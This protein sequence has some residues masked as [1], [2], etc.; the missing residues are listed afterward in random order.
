M[1][2]FLRRML[3]VVLGRQLLTFILHRRPNV[4][5]LGRQIVLLVL[6]AATSA[7][8]GWLLIESDQANRRKLTVKSSTKP[9][10]LLPKP[11]PTLSLPT[12]KAEANRVDDLTIIDGIGKTYARVLN[13]LG[14]KTFREL[15]RR[16]PAELSRQSNGRISAE[17]IRHQDWI[18][19]AKLLSRQQM[20][21]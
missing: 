9:Q 16:D 8:I 5:K 6:S 11:E 13:E 18:G 17:R 7:I 19:Q 20:V 2:R 3:F 14:V 4:L 10:Q 15:A 1:N 21:K 12:P